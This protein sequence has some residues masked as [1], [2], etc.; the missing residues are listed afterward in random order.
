MLQNLLR[1]SVPVRDLPSI[2]EAIGDYAPKTKD[3]ELLTELVR[4]RLAPQIS[5]Q[6]APDGRLGVLVL[7][8]RP[9]ASPGTV[10]CTVK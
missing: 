5:A 8:R 10:H 4:E 7:F 3:P 6:L 2:L 1:E 9:C